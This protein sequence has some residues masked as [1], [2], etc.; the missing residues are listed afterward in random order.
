MRRG[1]TAMELEYRFAT[2]N[3]IENLMQISLDATE[4]GRALYSKCGFKDSD[5][6]MVLVRDLRC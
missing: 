5:E 2:A 4:S 1:D 3:D 6:C